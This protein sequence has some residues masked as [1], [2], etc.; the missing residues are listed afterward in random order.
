M[1]SPHLELAF[2][3]AG[4]TDGLNV[5][6]PELTQDRARLDLEGGDDDSSAG[7]ALRHAAGSVGMGVR[8]YI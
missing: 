1:R 5:V 4:A 8:L 3:K 7:W 2:E 6:F